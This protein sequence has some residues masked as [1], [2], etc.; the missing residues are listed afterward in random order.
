MLY[1]GC[2]LQNSEFQNSVRNIRK[3]NLKNDIINPHI[4]FVYKP[5]IIDHSIFGEII[6]IKI[7]GY[8]NDGVN[9]GVSVSVFSE[10]NIIMDLFSKLEAPH[11]TISLSDEGKAVNTR[12][13][14][15]NEIE[16]IEISGIFGG[17]TLDKRII[18]KP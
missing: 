17:C 18:L 2:F 7:T 9:E 16:P 13:L 8:G 1:I 4:T 5:I 15:F 14:H 12:Y 10:N 3:N 11:I 6:K